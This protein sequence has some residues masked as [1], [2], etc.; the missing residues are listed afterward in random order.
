MEVINELYTSQIYKW[1][2]WTYGDILG[3]QHVGMMVW[4]TKNIYYKRV[5]AE[6]S[7]I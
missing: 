6:V 5:Y 1:T 4:S 2:D 3:C 7:I